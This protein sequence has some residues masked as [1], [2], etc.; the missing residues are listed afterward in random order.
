LN[1]LKIKEKTEKEIE[2]LRQPASSFNENETIHIGAPNEKL[3]KLEKEENNLEIEKIK[4]LNEI[5][6][7]IGISELNLM[8]TMK[9]IEKQKITNISIIIDK[10]QHLIIKNN[11]HSRFEAIIENETLIEYKKD[12][13]LNNLLFEYSTFV[14]FGIIC[15]IIGGAGIHYCIERT[16]HYRGFIRYYKDINNRR[17]LISK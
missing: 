4:L 6:N 5:D 14:Y 17:V 9:F 16:I 11:F 8:E 2:K 15:F 10:E 13:N 7:I 1:I 12:P 3:M